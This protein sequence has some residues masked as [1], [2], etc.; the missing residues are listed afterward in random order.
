MKFYSFA[1]A[2]NVGMYARLVPFLVLLMQQSSDGAD[3]IIILLKLPST[4]TIFQGS[5]EVKI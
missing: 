5:K 1:P 4:D 2:W 3:H